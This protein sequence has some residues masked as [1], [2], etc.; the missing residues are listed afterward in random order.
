MFP[1]DAEFGL[2]VWVPAETLKAGPSDECDG[3]AVEEGSDI[4]IGLG[5]GTSTAPFK[6][7]ICMV[8]AERWLEQNRGLFNTGKNPGPSVD[9]SGDREEEEEEEG[10]GVPARSTAA[11][12][13][14]AKERATAEPKPNAFAL[15]LCPTSNAFALTTV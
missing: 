6:H 15:R 4:R 13:K 9:R 12:R 10:K 14:E 3:T 8:H 11:A 5:E 1:L 7:G 2:T